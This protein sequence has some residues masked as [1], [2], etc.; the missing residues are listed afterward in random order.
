MSDTPKP[1]LTNF[2]MML[3]RSQTDP[4]V[5]AAKGVSGGA[6]TTSDKGGSI[7]ATATGGVLDGGK[8]KVNFVPVQQLKEIVGIGDKISK[9]MHMLRLSQ[10]NLTANKLREECLVRW[11]L[12]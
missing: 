8:L 10:G 1:S 3:K 6:M 12:K 4:V 9:R 11:I 2:M 7:S 5:A